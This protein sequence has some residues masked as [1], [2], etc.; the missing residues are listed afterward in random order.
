MDIPPARLHPALELDGI[1][2]RFG[3]RWVLRGATL[4]VDAG[5]IVALTGRNGSGK[6]TLLRIAGTLLRPTRGEARVYG[7]DVIENSDDVRSVVGFFGHS[8][9]LY[10]DLTAAENLRF[11]ARMLGA[12]D[13]ARAVAE[14]LEFVGLGREANERVR[15]FSS[16][17]QR[18]LAL[19]RVRLHRPR[20][21]LMDE[22]FNSIDA[23]GVDLV[24]A[25]LAE[26]RDTGG[27]A[28]V[29]THEL[30]RGERSF[31]R[32]VRLEDGRIA[33][34]F[35]PQAVEPE[36]RVIPGPWVTERRGL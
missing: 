24:N 23:E 22:P 35:G 20:L 12:P 16:G 14:S 8:S 3:A 25:V 33:R 10:H 6:T 11:A 7:Y 17:M 1:A 36:T 13:D 31:T 4:R 34:P 29:V 26:T 28:V 9:G 27:A 30:A 15:H 21:L 5:E 18:R 32:I 2:R 19:A